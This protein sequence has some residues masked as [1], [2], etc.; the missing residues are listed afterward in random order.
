MTVYA[1]EP[2]NISDLPFDGLGVLDGFVHK[3]YLA[4]LAGHRFV[5]NLVQLD[6]S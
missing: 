3:L 6:K 2:D 1:H 4:V 5:L